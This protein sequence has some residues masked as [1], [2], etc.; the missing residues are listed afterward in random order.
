TV[1]LDAFL[2]MLGGFVGFE[3]RILRCERSV[4]EGEGFLPACSP[5]SE[6]WMSELSNERSKAE[7]GMRYTPL[8]DYLARLVEHYERSPPSEPA[9]YRRRHAEIVFAASRA[10]TAPAS[11]R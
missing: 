6:R 11:P 2:A 1:S 4:L 3:P 10:L 8:R 9:G 7:L 5:F